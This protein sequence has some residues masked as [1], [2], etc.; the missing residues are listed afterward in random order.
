M[1][2]WLDFDKNKD[3]SKKIRER[4][5]RLGELSGTKIKKLENLQA[6]KKI[7]T[8]DQEFNEEIISAKMT[9]PS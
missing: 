4:R 5:D 8:T 9:G 7:T 1:T 3:L 2:R 6:K